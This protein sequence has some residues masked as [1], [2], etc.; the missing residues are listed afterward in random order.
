[1]TYSSPILYVSRF[2]VLSADVE[3]KTQAL[4][5]VQLLSDAE[6]MTLG[7]R[8]P[9]VTCTSFPATPALVIETDEEICLNTAP[10]QLA[11]ISLNRY[12]TLKGTDSKFIFTQC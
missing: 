2:R 11:Q 12:L 9:R 8:I 10:T 7:Q 4:N 1:M 3:T 6:E 5:N